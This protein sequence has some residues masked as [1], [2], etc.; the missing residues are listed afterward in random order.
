MV[1]GKKKPVKSRL[2]PAER[3]AADD[4]EARM[5]TPFL[6]SVVFFAIMSVVVCTGLF[7]LASAGMVRFLESRGGEFLF[8]TLIRVDFSRVGTVEPRWIF[9]IPK[10][11]VE[12]YRPW[13][14]GALAIG[15]SMFLL[16]MLRMAFYSMGKQRRL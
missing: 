6:L 5:H 15:G 1:Q 3:R 13:G 2:P 8:F 14:V 11:A 9:Y 7:W 12:M 16:R 4:M 10:S